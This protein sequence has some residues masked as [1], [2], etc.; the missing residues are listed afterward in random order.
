MQRIWQF[1]LAA[2]LLSGWASAQHAKLVHRGI[3]GD[4][5]IASVAAE[6]RSLTKPAGMIVSGT[7]VDARRSPVTQ[8]H[9]LPTVEVRFRVEQAIRG[10]GRQRTLTFREWAGLWSDGDRYRPGE[11]C[12]LFLYPASHLG[13]T[14][15]VQGPAGKFA[16]DDTGQVF[17]GRLRASQLPGAKRTALPAADIASHTSA[18]RISATR[19]SDRV[20]LREF[21]SA[22]RQAMQEER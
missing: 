21:T 3:E 7:V 11:R 13:L 12:V 17:L 14:S 5:T 4:G 16:I 10:V 22:I 9:A 18:S 20:S 2:L 8:P 6:L 1:V 19:I 15:P